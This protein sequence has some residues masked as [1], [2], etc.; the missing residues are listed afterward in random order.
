MNS[1]ERLKYPTILVF[2]FVAQLTYQG[3]EATVIQKT[4]SLRTVRS[5]T[6][7]CLKVAM[8]MEVAT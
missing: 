6:T 8:T 1:A 7:L 3:K 4:E 5:S 2:C